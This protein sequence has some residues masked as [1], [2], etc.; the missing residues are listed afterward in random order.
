MVER[1]QCKTILINV[2]RWINSSFA[3]RVLRCLRNAYAVQHT[4]IRSKEEVTI[5]VTFFAV[6]GHKSRDFVTCYCL[7]LCICRVYPS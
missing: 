7:I 1:Q 3:T 6:F 4:I 2:W 5:R